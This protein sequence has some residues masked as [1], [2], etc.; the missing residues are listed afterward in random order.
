MGNFLNLQDFHSIFA[1]IISICW[2]LLFRE[3]EETIICINEY[4]LHSFVYPEIVCTI[5]Y[6]KS[7][8]V[9]FLLH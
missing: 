3:I 7:N 2:G 4:V 6:L 1:N 9:K 5:I 8:I